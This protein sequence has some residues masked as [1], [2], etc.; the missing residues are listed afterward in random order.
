MNVF[1]LISKIKYHFQF[2]VLLCIL[3]SGA[4]RS[5]M[6][7]E[8][9]ICI[10]S[11]TAIEKTDDMERIRN[12]SSVLIEEDNTTSPENRHNSIQEQLPVITTV[13]AL[14]N[15]EVFGFNPSCHKC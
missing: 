12:D 4:L 13:E 3:Y 8:F 11:I 7:F 1:S 2:F 9:Q 5:M 6:S 14:P 15:A 10:K